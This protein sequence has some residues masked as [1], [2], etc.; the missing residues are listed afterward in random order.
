[1]TGSFR[2]ISAVL[3]FGCALLLGAVAATTITVRAQG[4]TGQLSGTVADPNGAVVQ[5]ATVTV[6]NRDTGLER[7]AVTDANGAFAVQLLPP[8]VY[9]VEVSAQGF[10]TA[11]VEDVRV[12]ITETATVNVSLPVAGVASNVLVSADPPTVQLE[13]SQVGRVIDGRAISQLPLPTR[14]F[15]QLL[16]LSPGTYASVA[17]NTELGRGDVTVSVNGQRTTSNNVR[18]NGIDANSVGTNSTPNLAVPATD[19]LQEFIVQTSTYDASTG[20]NAGGNVEAVTKSGS[21]DFHGNI[22]EF[23]RN[24]KLNANDFF[25]N[26]AGRP[27]PIFRRNQFGGTLGGSLVRD[28]FFFFGSYQGTR[29][30]NGA[31]LNNSLTFPII[32]PRLTDNNRTA[33]GLAAAF[34]L[35][36]AQISPV[37]VALLQARLPN[38]QFAIPSAGTASGLSPISGVS[39]FTEN[40]FN[41]NLDYTLSQKH[42][43]SG[44]GFF[45]SNPTVQS[46]YNFAGLGNGNQQLPG[47]GGS[48]DIIQTLISITDTYVFSPSVVNQARIGFS[49]LRVTS[50]PEEPITAS[51]VGMTTPFGATYPGLPTIFVTGQFSLGSSPLADQSSRINT[52]T[53]S[54]TLSFNVGGRHRFRAGGEFRPSRVDFYFNAFTRGQINFPT[55]T[56]FLTG[57]SLT[58]LGVSIL[59]SGVFDRSLRTNDFAAFIQDDFKVNDRLTLNLGLRYD[60]FTFPRDIRGRLVNFIPEQFRAGTAL[61][62]AGPPNGIVQAGNGTL[63]GVPTVD[64]TLI[65]TDRNN[66]APRVGFAYRPTDSD[67]LVVRGGYGIY[68]DRPSTRLINT[69][70][71][72]YPYL[73]IGVGLLAPGVFRTFANPFISLPSPGAFPVATTVPSPLNP[74]SPLGV[75]ISG[76]FIDPEM[77]TPYVQQY[78]FNVQYEFFKNWL[79]EVGYVGSKGTKLLQV[80]TLNQPTYNPATGLFN[81]PPFGSFVS[82]NRNVTGGLQQV[83]ADGNSKYNSLQISVTKRFS[84]GLQLLSAYTLGK[85][86][87]TY[88]GTGVNEITTVPGDQLDLSTN[89]GPSDFDRRHRFV[90]SFVYDLPKLQTGSFLKRALFNNYQFNGIVTLQTGTPFSIIESNG[91]SVIQ[92]A[93]FAPGF[94][95]SAE[96]SGSTTDRLNS[97]FNTA[98]FTRSTLFLVGTTRNPAFDPSAPYGN[99]PRNFLYGPGQ[100]N[101]DFAVVKFMPFSERLRGEFRTEFFNIFNF[102]NF[103]NPINNVLAPA[104]FNPSTGTFVPT[105]GRI[106]STS[107]GP[108]V[109]QFAFKLNF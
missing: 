45:A 89:R 52:F 38:G 9:R 59:G 10:S 48:L 72:N 17:N 56:S 108:R 11:A 21:N 33:A 62:P 85:S 50:V 24:E 84:Q 91:T 104:V 95:G 20:R 8:G 4:T 64:D 99:T 58:S 63:P 15:Q 30:R 96:G 25:L 16:T 102:A 66:F 80:V 35:T 77:R 83:R 2:R 79:L 47:F 19:S 31:S 90:T 12:Q 54:D 60:M 53:V 57:G 70:L 65:P 94:S 14:N 69:Q 55:F 74:L 61:S 49:R 81:A 41:A 3:L 13:T 73:G 100:K 1:M 18:I 88:S 44:K 26:S 93:N 6:R 27:R 107:S 46:N 106:T 78:N 101:V 40:Q 109:I 43:L 51:S 92:R 7:Q 75:P 22:Y 29:E 82:T 39:R 97:Y 71:F 36:P 86:I 32:D 28:K 76:L 5:N 68:Y 42:T 34:G 105:F 87:D 23:F 98:A 67:R 103:A 37:A